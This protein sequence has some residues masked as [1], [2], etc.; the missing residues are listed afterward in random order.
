MDRIVTPEGVI[1]MVRPCAGLAEEIERQER[2]DNRRGFE[3]EASW[4][5]ATI[6]APRPLL[7]GGA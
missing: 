2:E 3:P 1:I 7:V 5:S 4:L 6:P